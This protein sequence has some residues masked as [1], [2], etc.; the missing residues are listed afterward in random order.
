MRMP[1][2]A[3]PLGDTFF[4][5][6]GVSASKSSEVALFFPRGEEALDFPPRLSSFREVASPGLYA[7][8]A[9]FGFSFPPFV[10]P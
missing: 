9:K 7:Q 6:I 5:G 4:P 3:A 8:C 1:V 10:F 2:A